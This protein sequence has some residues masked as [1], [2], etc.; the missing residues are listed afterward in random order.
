MIHRVSPVPKTIV[1]ELSHM[2]NQNAI[3]NFGEVEVSEAV[4]VIHIVASSHNPEE[5]KPAQRESN[6]EDRK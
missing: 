5:R 1:L 4:N 2:A 3:E 6:D